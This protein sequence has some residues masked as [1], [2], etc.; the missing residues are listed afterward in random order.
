MSFKIKI[1]SLDRGKGDQNIL[2]IENEFLKRLQSQAKIELIS[3]KSEKLNRDLKQ[4]ESVLFKTTAASF[5]SKIALTEKGKMLSSQEFAALF[6]KLML[7]ST[8]EVAFII[9]GASGLSDEALK[10]ADMLLSLSKMTLTHE[11][12]RMLLLEQIYRAFCI[13]NNH[14]Y[15]KE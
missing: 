11:M 5:V 8:N 7:Q 9:G 15:H 13:L 14:P 12:A 6:K 3:F 10:R 1:I 2:S 4:K